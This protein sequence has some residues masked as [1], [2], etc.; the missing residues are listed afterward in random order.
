M[1]FEPGVLE[2]ETH[3]AVN[4]IMGDS[5]DVPNVFQIERITMM[6]G[7]NIFARTGQNPADLPPDEFGKILMLI[8]KAIK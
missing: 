1:I 8:R 2:E 7:V 6:A 4:Q 5:K 3:K